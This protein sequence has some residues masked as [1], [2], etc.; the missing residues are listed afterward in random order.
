MTY[1]EGQNQFGYTIIKGVDITDVC[2]AD[3]QVV[4]FF[5]IS[6]GNGAVKVILGIYRSNNALEYIASMP[7]PRG[8]SMEQSAQLL[9]ANPTFVSL[10]DKYIGQI[11]KANFARLLIAIAPPDLVRNIQ[12]R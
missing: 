2:S 8:N 6:Q 1:F 11:D 10:D 9:L 3:S 5:G 12:M 7:L 4:A